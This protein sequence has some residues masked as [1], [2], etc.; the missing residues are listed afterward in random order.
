MRATLIG[1]VF[2]LVGSA[3]LA[4]PA[5]I[6]VQI[7]PK[8]QAKA[9][10]S[11]GTG[12][13]ARLAAYLEQS[14]ARELDRTGVLA[15]A[16]VELVLMDAVPTRPTFKQMSKKLGLST[17]SFGLG[18]ATISGRAIAIDGTI[19]PIRFAWYE[20]DIEQAPYRV[21]WS[22]ADTAVDRFAR[23]LARGHSQD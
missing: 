4:A 20:T 5:D 7:G 22:D 18:G 1:L 2:A 19:T 6:Q 3:A 13:I 8:L 15:G 23:R 17:R 21:T 10:E 16:R 12:D 14:V 11:L 9:E